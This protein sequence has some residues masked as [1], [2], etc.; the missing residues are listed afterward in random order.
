[1]LVT[2]S[3][4]LAGAVII[5]IAGAENGLA[6]IRSERLEL[7]EVT[8]KLGCDILKVQVGI[9]IYRGLNLIGLYM[10]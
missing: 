8:E 10:G 6:V 5:D 1:M 4:N 3:H 2:A 9:D 7:L